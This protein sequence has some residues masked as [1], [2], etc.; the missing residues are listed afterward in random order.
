MG[1]RQTDR[2]TET[3]AETQRERERYVCVSGDDIGVDPGQEGSANLGSVKKT[4]KYFDSHFLH[5]PCL[6]SLR[7]PLF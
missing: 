5:S 2:P 7:V 3:E 1:D 4:G 6:I